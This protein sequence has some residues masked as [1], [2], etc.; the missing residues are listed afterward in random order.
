MPPSTRSGQQ[1]INDYLDWCNIDHATATA[2][3]RATALAE[4]ENA[5]RKVLQGTYRNEQNV[6]CLHV[7]S[8]LHPTSA[9]LTLAAQGNASLTS[10]DIVFTAA[11]AGKVGEDVAVVIQTGT[12]LLSV[13]EDTATKIITITLATGGSTTSAVVSAC[14][15]LTL[16]TVTGGSSAAC[17]ALAHTH[18]ALTFSGNT[19]CPSGF[20]GLVEAPRFQYDGQDSKADLDIEEISP[21][22]MDKK[23][24]DWDGESDDPQYFCVRPK[25]LSASAGT[26]YEIVVM[27]PPASALVVNFRCRMDPAAITDSS[28]AYIVG[29]YN[30]ELLVLAQAK[31]YKELQAGQVN[32]PESV[33]LAK[34]MLDFVEEDEALYPVETLQ[35]SYAEEDGG[36]EA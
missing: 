4:L 24:R 8:F 19:A 3:Q 28:S 6:S 7:W 12:G 18:L 23:V 27:P 5:Y 25:A 13:A 9:S 11:S 31:A 22:A 21:E 34:M 16:A 15:A 26:T 36:L 35:R 33:N 30:F 2:T 20:A 29:N 14:S 1:L 10:Q 32:G 17:T